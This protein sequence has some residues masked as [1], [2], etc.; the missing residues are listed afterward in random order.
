M[1][2]LNLMNGTIQV[3]NLNCENP[4]CLNNFSFCFVCVTLKLEH[5]ASLNLNKEFC[6]ILLVS[7]FFGHLYSV[8]YDDVIICHLFIIN[9]S[10][11]IKNYLIFWGDAV[12]IRCIL[13]SECNCNLALT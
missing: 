12:S 6:T 4:V 13:R 11:K 1:L 9:S 10:Q 2:V 3:S 8:S 5:A 7:P